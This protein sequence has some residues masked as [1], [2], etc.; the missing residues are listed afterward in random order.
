[1]VKIVFCRLCLDLPLYFFVVVV[2]QFIIAKKTH[3]L[4]I[5]VCRPNKVNTEVKP[6]NGSLQKMQNYVRTSSI[7]TSTNIVN[8]R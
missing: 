7:Q 8:N 4:L 1:M 6:V 2:L 5:S 3:L